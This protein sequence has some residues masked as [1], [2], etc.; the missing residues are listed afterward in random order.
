[1][2]GAPADNAGYQIIALVGVDGLHELDHQCL[3]VAALA[4]LHVQHPLDAVDRIAGTQVSEILPVVAGKEPV[5]A[6]QAPAGA[7]GP[8]A[9]VGGAGVADDRTVLGIGGVLL[10]PGIWG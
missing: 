3:G 10:V 7:A 1:M 4:F 9:H 2:A 8:V 5:D 6:R